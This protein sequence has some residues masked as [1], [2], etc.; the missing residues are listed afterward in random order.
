MQTTSRHPFRI[1]TARALA[2]GLIFAAVGAG[3]HT[4]CVSTAAE[5]RQ[6]LTDASDGGLYAN[7]FAQ[8]NVST[9][10]YLTGNNPFHYS[11][12]SATSSL[13][14]TGGNSAG[15]VSQMLSP[16]TT[17]L[18]GHHATAVMQLKSANGTIVVTALTLQNGESSEPGGGLQIN[19]GISPTTTTYVENSIIRNNHSA[20][21]GG[22]V[23][24]YGGEVALDFDLIAGNSANQFGAG[25][26]VAYGN[27]NEMVHDTV[28]NNT[29]STT[30]G[31]VGGIYCGGSTYCSIGENIFWNNTTYGIYL[32]GTNA[33]MYY[34]DYGSRGGNDPAQETFSISANPAFVNPAGGNFRLSGASPALAFGG[35]NFLQSHD[36]DGN[37]LPESGKVDLGAYEETIFFDGFDAD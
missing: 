14:V 27:F 20:G 31:P 22:G 29:A 24:M 10:T 2:T 23:Y 26:V 8:V 3:A 37:P 17:I 28:A 7:E 16:A 34:N 33:Q 30:S 15:C 25:F 9:G 36:L 6:A 12:T 19:Y 13:Y 32:G 18:D 35:I 5:L 1:A 21:L 11:N 4:F